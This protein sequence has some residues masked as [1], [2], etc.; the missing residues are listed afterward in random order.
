MM[1]EYK[2]I[3]YEIFFGSSD[4]LKKF[5]QKLEYKPYKV[6]WNWED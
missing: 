4:G 5:K 1:I 3:M 6:R 2:Y